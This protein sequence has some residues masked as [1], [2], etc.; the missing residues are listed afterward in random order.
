[1][2]KLIFVQEAQGQAMS[3]REA[4]EALAA[5]VEIMIDEANAGML[6]ALRAQGYGSPR[7]EVPTEPASLY[8]VR[9]AYSTWSERY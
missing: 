1:V 4:S 7:P 6:R 2:Q 8:C 3:D 9:H 5:M